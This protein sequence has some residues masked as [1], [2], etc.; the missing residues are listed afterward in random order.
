MK[1]LIGYIKKYKWYAI[2]GPIFK[3]LE[4]VLELLNPI[5]VARLIDIGVTNKD[6]MYIGK[7]GALI[8]ISCVASFCFSL[9]SQK[10]A[11]KTSVGVATNMQGR[12]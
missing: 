5:L 1:R 7:I 10:C 9:I 4:A 8:F 3:L 11:A 12:V 2:L 6:Y